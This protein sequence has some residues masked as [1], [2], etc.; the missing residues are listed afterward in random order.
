VGAKF[1]T[2]FPEGLLQDDSRGLS[3][4]FASRINA[5][6]TVR[7]VFRKKPMNKLI[8]VS[9]DWCNPCRIMSEILRDIDLEGDFNTTLENIDAGQD[10]EILVKH[11]I[12]SVPFFI[13]EDEYGGVIRTHQ[14]AMTLENTRKFLAGT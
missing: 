5:R 1:K 10:K 12:R 7:N 14:G 4:W 6:E 8:K 2:G 11:Q 3:K 13:L 9:T